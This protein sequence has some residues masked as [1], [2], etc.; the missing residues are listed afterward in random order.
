M[1]WTLSWFWFFVGLVCVIAGIL[2]LRYYRQIADNMASGVA[3][4]DRVKL[5]G[6]IFAG[7]GIVFMFNIHSLILY[8]IF[9]FIMPDAFPF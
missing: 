5:F 7:A 6:I 1:K 2:I 3:S 4:Y 9:H 8:V